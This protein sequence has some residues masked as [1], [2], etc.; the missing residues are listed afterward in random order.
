MERGGKNTGELEKKELQGE[1]TNNEQVEKVKNTP[2]EKESKLRR[3]K[4]IGGG[5]FI[6]N[7]RMIK[8]GQTFLADPDEIP[9]AFQDTVIAVDGD[10][11]FG[12][13]VNKKPETPPP[14]PK[15]VK[16]VVYE[17]RQRQGSQWWD[18]FRSDETKPINTKGMKEEFAKQMVEDLMK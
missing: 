4:K 10:V 16:A 15:D 17:A 8:P 9:V 14:G 3:F 5:S 18:V 6:L 13:T 2:T 7:K 11:N 1:N 12:K